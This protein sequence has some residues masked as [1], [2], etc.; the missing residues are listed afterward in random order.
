[1]NQIDATDHEAADKRNIV[2]TGDF[3][4]GLVTLLEHEL[5]EFV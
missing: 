5:V 2:V 4:A 1:M 3:N